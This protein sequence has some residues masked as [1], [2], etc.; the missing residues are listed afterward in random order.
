MDDRRSNGRNGN[1]G[2][3]SVT[4]SHSV[5]DCEQRLYERLRWGDAVV[6]LVVTAAYRDSVSCAAEVAIA[7]FKGSHRIGVR[8]R[9]RPW[10][11]RGDPR[12]GS[13]PLRVGIG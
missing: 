10:G 4:T 2:P 1:K 8:G 5:G 13:A 12:P 9:S 6:C 3:I 11:W 7:G